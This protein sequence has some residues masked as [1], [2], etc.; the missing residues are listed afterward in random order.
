MGKYH[1]VFAAGNMFSI[2]VFTWAK[3]GASETWHKHRPKGENAI[4]S[5]YFTNIDDHFNVVLRI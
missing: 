3:F 4:G 2:N 5:V 1:W